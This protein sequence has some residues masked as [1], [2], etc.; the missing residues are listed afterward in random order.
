MGFTSA[1]G[2]VDVIQKNGYALRFKAAFPESE[3]PV[4]PENYAKAIEAYESTLITPSAFDRYLGGEKEALSEQQKSGLRLFMS[5]G[6][7]DC[8]SGELLGGKGVKKFGVHRDYW[9]ATGSEQHD[10]GLF[11]SS[12]KDEDK[13]RFRVSML[14][15][16]EKTGPYFHDGSVVGLGEAVRVMAKV[17]LD[18]ELDDMQLEYIV[19]FLSSLTC[20]LPRNYAPPNDQGDFR[21]YPSDRRTAR[22]AVTQPYGQGDEGGGPGD[23]RD[24]DPDALEPVAGGEER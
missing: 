21:A 1:A 16:I 3:N 24:G 5:V 8:H 20:E 23:G 6:C 22:S 13:Y 19:A 12:N 2:V 7:A 18:Q 9:A 17:Q 4:S 14:R 11:E 10:S 15:N